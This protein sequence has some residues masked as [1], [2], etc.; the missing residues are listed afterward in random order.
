MF[1]FYAYNVIKMDLEELFA[2]TKDRKLIKAHIPVLQ[3]MEVIYMH[4]ETKVQ[5]LTIQSH[6]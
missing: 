2:K 6:R 5:T 4:P 1:S 3:Y